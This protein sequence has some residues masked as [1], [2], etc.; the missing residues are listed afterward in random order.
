[1]RVVEKADEAET[2]SLGDRAV[3]AVTEALVHLA[4]LEDPAAL[5][6]ADPVARANLLGLTGRV[7]RGEPAGQVVLFVWANLQN[8]K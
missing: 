7:E 2:A 4:A 1:V 8:S 6:L 3:V 5:E